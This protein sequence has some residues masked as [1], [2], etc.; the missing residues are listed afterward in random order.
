VP[1]P[2]STLFQRLE[3]ERVELPSFSLSCLSRFTCRWAQPDLA[4]E[5]HSG[6]S[7]PVDESDR[8]RG[9]L[10]RCIFGLSREHRSSEND[11]LIATGA[12]HDTNEF[13]HKPARHR[14]AQLLDL[15]GT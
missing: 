15:H 13:V 5:E 6:E 4:L 3:K 14:L 10:A 1:I 11:G 7:L 12:Q 8:Q 9:L 2:P